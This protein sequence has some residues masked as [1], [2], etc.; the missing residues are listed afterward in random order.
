[1]GLV[2]LCVNDEKYR[3]QA[4]LNFMG[5]IFDLAW[6][7]SSFDDWGGRYQFA[8]P[9]CDFTRG[10]INAVSL[11]GAPKPRLHKGDLQA[12]IKN[13]PGI[14]FSKSGFI[15]ALELLFEVGIQ[16]KALHARQF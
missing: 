2:V 8:N 10:S 1:M 9:I 15:V 12:P 5:C 11:R 16:R 3:G 4:A 7:G 13:R 14:A 6:A